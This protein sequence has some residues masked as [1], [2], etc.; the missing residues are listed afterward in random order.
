ML[1]YQT[2]RGS[3]LEV[4]SQLQAGRAHIQPN[5]L[6]RAW[7]VGKFTKHKAAVGTAKPK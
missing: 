4:L 6:A 3:A 1:H 7:S 2:E 5:N